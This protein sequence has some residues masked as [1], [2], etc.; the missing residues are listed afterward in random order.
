MP[1][2][3]TSHGG[4]VTQLTLHVWTAFPYQL[5]QQSL[6]HNWQL[7]DEQQQQHAG[8]ANMCLLT[9]LDMAGLASD[10]TTDSLPGS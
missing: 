2:F 10:Q 7:A 3:V 6:E 4:K 5:W 8:T 1:S 9:K